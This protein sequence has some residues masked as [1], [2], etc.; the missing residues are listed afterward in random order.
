MHKAGIAHLDFAAHNLLHDKRTGGV[1]VIDFEG[2]QAIVD[3]TVPVIGLHSP[4]PGLNFDGLSDGFASD[5][6]ACAHSFK[7]IGRKPPNL[8]GFWAC[9]TSFDGSLLIWVPPCV[10]QFTDSRNL[11]TPVWELMLAK[12]PAERPSSDEALRQVQS[13]LSP[14]GIRSVMSADEFAQS[15]LARFELHDSGHGP[16]SILNSTPH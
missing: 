2:S 9:S 8:V 3:G 6:Y 14:L 12:E 1:Y 13:V 4:T 16:S 5:V 15:S 11:L 10:L 7:C